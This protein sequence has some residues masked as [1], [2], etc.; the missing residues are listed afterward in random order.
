M[1]DSQATL[2]NWRLPPFNREAFSKVREI[3]PTAA[4]NWNIVSAVQDND[5]TNRKL[6]VKL[7]QVSK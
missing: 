1:E 7:K 3:M 5:S 4:I 2:A 6:T